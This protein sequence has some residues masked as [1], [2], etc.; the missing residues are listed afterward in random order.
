MDQLNEAENAALSEIAIKQGSAG[1]IVNGHGIVAPDVKDGGYDKA[2]EDVRRLQDELTQQ[3]LM[4]EEGYREFQ[5]RMA[6]EE[7]MENWIKVGVM[8]RFCYLKNPETMKALSG[9]CSP[10]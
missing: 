5:E 9:R 4:S 8:L 6:Q 3:S 7:K 2:L 1:G 10:E